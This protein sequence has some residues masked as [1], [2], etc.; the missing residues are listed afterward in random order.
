MNW[1]WEESREGLLNGQEWWATGGMS[2]HQPPNSLE[3]EAEKH[4]QEEGNPE[5]LTVVRMGLKLGSPTWRLGVSTH[6]LQILTLKMFK[7]WKLFG[8]C[9]Q[10]S[11]ERWSYCV[12]VSSGLVTS[13]PLSA[14]II[15]SLPPRWMVSVILGSPYYTDW[16][17]FFCLFIY[18][19]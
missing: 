8:C 19:I 18:N 9:K 5:T 13:H 7:V 11:V 15:C 2:L 14:G 12:G 10:K 17:L 1:S 6:N 4:A 16:S 3:G